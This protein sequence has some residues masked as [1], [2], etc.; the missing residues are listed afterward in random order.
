MR[1]Q[2][3]SYCGRCHWNLRW[4]AV[5]SM[6]QGMP[7][8]TGVV[9]DSKLAASDQTSPAPLKLMPSTLKEYEAPAVR[10]VAKYSLT[11]AL[12]G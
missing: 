12:V 7:T 5:Y 6:S 9:H 4:A 8:A 10:P 2:P 3:P 1:A 11:F